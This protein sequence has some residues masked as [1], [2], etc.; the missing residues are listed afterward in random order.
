[1]HKGMLIR[2]NPFKKH[3][4]FVIIKMSVRNMRLKLGKNYENFKKHGQAEF[5]VTA[6]KNWFCK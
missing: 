5:Q 2:N 1:M 4:E 6:C 3:K